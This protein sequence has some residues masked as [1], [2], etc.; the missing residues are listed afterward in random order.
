MP[1]PGVP[2]S[3]VFR[4]IPAEA[5]EYTSAAGKTMTFPPVFTRQ[6]ARACINARLPK[7]L[8]ADRPAAI[9]FEARGS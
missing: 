7:P 4:V 1:V 9:F 6:P 3:F 2:A 8:A 5:R